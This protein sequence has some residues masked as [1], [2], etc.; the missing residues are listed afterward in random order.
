MSERRKIYAKWRIGH[1]TRAYADMAGPERYRHAAM[2]Q[3]EKEM[4]AMRV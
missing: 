3:S 2:L 1:P 4:R